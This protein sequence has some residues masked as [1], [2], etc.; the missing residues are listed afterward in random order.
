MARA[1]PLYLGRKNLRAM[2]L[3]RKILI[4]DDDREDLEILTEVFGQLDNHMSIHTVENGSQV[5]RY[6]SSI[7]DDD[8]PCVIVLDYKMPVLNA[9]EVLEKIRD[10]ARY[11]HIPKVVWSSSGRKEDMSR[12]LNAGAKEYFI[13]PSKTSELKRMAGIML[14]YCGS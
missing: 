7:A 12:C 6:L 3:K 1:L 11:S 9:A 8:L 5:F 10:E 14:R 2:P 13:K 4:A